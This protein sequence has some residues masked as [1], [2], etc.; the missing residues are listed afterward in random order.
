MSNIH[1]SHASYR[2]YYHVVWGT[3]HR[4]PALTQEIANR[5]VQIINDICN[6]YN[7]HVLGFHAE[8]EHVHILISLQPQYSVSEVINKIKGTSSKI[9]RVEFPLLL[10]DVDNKSLWADGY[11]AHTVGD[12]NTSQIKSYLDKQKEHHH[13]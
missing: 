1:S 9:L 12:V 10:T 6:K 7:Y 2:L 13:G 5:M 11:C 4:K 8:P 3:K